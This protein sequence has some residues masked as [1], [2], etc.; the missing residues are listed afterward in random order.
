M[1]LC[2]AQLTDPQ[3]PP[4]PE[5]FRNVA[6]GLCAELD[7]LPLQDRVMCTLDM[8][9]E[10]LEYAAYELAQVEKP[11]RVTRLV[12]LSADMQ[13]AAQDLRDGVAWPTR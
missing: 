9:A 4:T 7:T 2:M 13:T 10:I 8:A 6:S 1:R 12:L 5:S 11:G 3:S